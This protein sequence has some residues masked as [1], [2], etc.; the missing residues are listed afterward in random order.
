MFNGARLDDLMIKQPQFDL[1]QLAW[2]CNFLVFR[3]DNTW[4][5]PL[6]KPV[7]L[8][9][10]LLRFFLSMLQHQVFSIYFGE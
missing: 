6:F 7:C 3:L 8:V 10:V 5:L 2:I 9:L 4:Y 1:T